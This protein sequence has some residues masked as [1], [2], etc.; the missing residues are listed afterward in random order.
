MNILAVVGIVICGLILIGIARATIFTD[1]DV[2]ED[3]D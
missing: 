1:K 3:I 2:R